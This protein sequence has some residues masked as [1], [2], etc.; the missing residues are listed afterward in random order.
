MKVRLHHQ[1]IRFR[2]E[3]TEVEQLSWGD[4]ISTRIQLGPAS[5]Y[6]ELTMLEGPNPAL[7]FQEGATRVQIPS[8]WTTGW[9]QSD[10]VGFEFEFQSDGAPPLAVVIEKD[11]PCAHTAEGKAVFGRPLKMP[12]RG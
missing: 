6:F 4:P 12:F 8:S 2:L 7:S 3:E 5:I 10:T 9:N 1:Y 11:Y